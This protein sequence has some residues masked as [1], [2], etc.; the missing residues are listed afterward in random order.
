LHNNFGIPK[1]QQSDLQLFI[2]LDKK[3]WNLKQKN[4]PKGVFLFQERIIN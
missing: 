3:P 4:A 2:L 1:I